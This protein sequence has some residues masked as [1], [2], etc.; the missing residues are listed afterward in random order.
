M[1]LPEVGSFYFH[2]NI[3][4]NAEIFEKVLENFDLLCVG[5]NKSYKTKLFTAD[6]NVLGHVEFLQFALK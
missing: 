2:S 6:I 1:V 4:V 5:I 3:V